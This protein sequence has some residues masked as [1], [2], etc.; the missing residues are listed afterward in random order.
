MFQNS[1]DNTVTFHRRQKAAEI[2]T[3]IVNESAEITAS[4]S[5][6]PD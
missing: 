3:F 4:V 1:A 6:E 5:G 2:R